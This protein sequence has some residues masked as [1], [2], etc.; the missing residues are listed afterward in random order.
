MTYKEKRSTE[1]ILLGIPIRVL[2]LRCKAGEFIEDTR[3]VMV[4]RAGARIS[5]KH[6]VEPNDILR[7]I[8]LHNYDK[9]DFRVVAFAG[10]TDRDVVEWGIES[11]EPSRSIWGIEFAH[12]LVESSGAL[13]RCQSCQQEVFAP[14]TPSA[15]EGLKAAGILERPCNECGKLTTW[16]LADVTRQP[17]EL[18]G[19][20]REAPP[21]PLARP[22]EPSNQRTNER[23]GTKLPILV[24]GGQG[25]EEISKTENVSAAGLAVSLA[26]ELNP[27]DS[28]RVVYPYSSE[29]ES[30]EQQAE[31]RRR[32]AYAF[33]GRRL[34]GLRL[35]N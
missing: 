32:A 10:K 1:R 28:L 4:N 2:G 33:A 23:Y 31:V 34:Y 24:R 6:P 21:P 16:K 22:A 18:P 12:P 29:R 3:T 5:L 7:V 26:M 17:R 25:Q 14:L 13:I 35:V 20:S 30:I 19:E 9:A 15:L 8:N 27:G 11:L